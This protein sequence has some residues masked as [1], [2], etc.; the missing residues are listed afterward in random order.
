MILNFFVIIIVLLLVSSQNA[1]YLLQSHP[2]QISFCYY[3][4]GSVWNFRIRIAK[5]Q[6]L[7]FNPHLLKYKIFKG[8]LATGTRYEH[9]C[10]Y[11]M[12][13]FKHTYFLTRN[14]FFIAHHI[15]NFEINLI[16][17]FM[18][19][20][21][22]LYRPTIDWMAERMKNVSRRNNAWYRYF[23]FTF[24]IVNDIEWK[25][26]MIINPT[27]ESFDDDSQINHTSFLTL[28]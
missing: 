25:D 13:L 14:L 1:L 6:Q 8:W 7:M 19:F 17:T 15:H 9:F 12:L 3:D 5:I 28:N 22:I 21:W 27:V 20:C 16:V 11:Q 24:V 2:T 10:D 23:I 4:H 26:E 18:S